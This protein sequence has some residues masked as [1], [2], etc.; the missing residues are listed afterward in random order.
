MEL[1]EKRCCMSVASG[2]SEFRQRS[3]SKQIAA[4]LVILRPN[5]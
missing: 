5:V 2:A 4:V 1:L 3:R